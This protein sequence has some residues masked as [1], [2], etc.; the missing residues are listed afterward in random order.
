MADYYSVIARAVSR[1]PSK[2]DEARHAVYERVRTVFQE[3]LRKSD[4]PLSGIELAKE[5]AAL[6]TA[7]SRVEA[8]FSSSDMQSGARE[9]IARYI[10]FLI[11]G[12]AFLAGLATVIRTERIQSPA[13]SQS[14]INGQAH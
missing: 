9:Q 5:K 3:T 8:D 4:P 1:L 10:V 11:T 12:V 6:D 13:A 14:S 2:T 7:I